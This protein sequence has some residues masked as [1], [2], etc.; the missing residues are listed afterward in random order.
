VTISN[1]EN[2]EN[3]QRANA[4][5][6][7][8]VQMNL[9]VIQDFNNKKA[10]S[11]ATIARALCGKHFCFI[12]RFITCNK[13]AFSRSFQFF[14]HFIISPLLNQLLAGLGT[15]DLL[16]LNLTYY[17]T[18]SQRAEEFV[19]RGLDRELISHYLEEWKG[20]LARARQD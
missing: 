10:N 18:I 1:Q 2:G 5:N 4:E 12:H 20:P 7:N 16:W 11:H 6:D 17:S 8:R 19:V 9:D 15:W 3:N 14:G 13:T